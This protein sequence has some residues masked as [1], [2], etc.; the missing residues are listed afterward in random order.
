MN[1]FVA[2]LI[3]LTSC[4]VIGPGKRG[5]K[6]SMGKASAEAMEPGAYFWL[7][8]FCGNSKIDIRIQKTDVNTSAASK[9]MQEVTTELAINWS[10]DPVKVVETFKTIGDEEDVYLR[11]IAPAVSEVMKS[12]VSHRSA[13]EILTKRMELKSDIDTGLKQRLSNYGVILYDV[14]IVDFKFSPQFTHAIEEKQIAE[15]K[16]KQAE[17]D[18]VR[19]SKEADA[20][21]NKAIGQSKA[22][23]LLKLTLTSELLQMRAI[24]KWDGK[25]PQVTG[26]GAL[27]FINLKVGGDK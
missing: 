3:L 5:V 4:S 10:I 1:K 25:F 23:N 21:V 16:A 11:V 13:E 8:Y 22:Q 19:A 15:Q 12:A 7:P 14:S 26:G 24:E 2:I 18:A 20:E 9:D 27:P 17:Y 6:I